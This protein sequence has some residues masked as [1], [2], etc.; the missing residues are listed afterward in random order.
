MSVSFASFEQ[1]QVGDE[2][3][4]R[5]AF[6]EADI[7]AFAALSGDHNPLHLDDT[8]ATR[9]RFP[10]RV[11]HGMLSAAQVSAMIGMRLPGPGAL[12]T[13]QHFNFLGPV[14]VGDE[15]TFVLRVKQKSEGSRTL[16][17]D[18]RA[19]NQRGEAVLSGEGKVMVLEP[20][21]PDQPGPREDEA[22]PVALVTGSSRG[23][24]AA[25]ARELARR[26]H[27]VVVNCRRNL[28]RA[29]LLAADIRAQGGA[30]IACQAD[31]GDPAAVGRMCR[32]AES[33]FG[34]P[35]LVLVNNA[36][37]DVHAKPVEALAY[38][39]LEAHLNTQLKGAFVCTQAVLGAMLERGAGCI[40]NVGSIV[41]TENPPTDWLAYTVAKS[42]LLGLTRSLAVELGPKGVRV[43]MVSPGMTETDMV[44]DVSPRARKL[45]AMQVPLRRLGQPADVAHVVAMLCSEDAG[46][47]HGANIPVSGGLAS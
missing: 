44:R 46:F 12:W 16:V 22:P 40:V 34:R 15:V 9:A 31:V 24:G 38:E 43:N 14:F 6:V 2:V 5:K 23:I 41:T 7:E 35:I 26:G 19:E 1:I 10:G 25:I 36:A 45:L 18:L 4:L 33:A 29:E 32:A 30:A 42:A 28:E 8:F 21:E 11:V 37:G 3:A 17:V 47:V 39:D 20:S 27:P 13:E